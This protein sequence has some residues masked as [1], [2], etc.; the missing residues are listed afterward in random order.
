MIETNVPFRKPKSNNAMTAMMQK[1]IERTFKIVDD[2]VIDFTNNKVGIRTKAN[3]ILT[4][5]PVYSDPVPVAEG[6]PAQPQSIVDWELSQNIFGEMGFD[7]PAFAQ[8]RSFND[9]K[10]GDIILDAAGKTF[11]WVIE[12]KVKSL[13]VKRPSGTSTTYTAPNVAMMGTGAPTYM[14]IS[15]MM[16]GEMGTMLPMI[17]M[18]KEGGKDLKKMLPFMMMANQGQGAAGLNAMMPIMMMMGDSDSDMEKLL[19]MMMMMNPGMM[20]QMTG[21]PTQGTT[22]DQAA[23]QQANPM[24]GMMMQNNMMQMMMMQSFMGK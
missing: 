1:F 4:C 18:M 17:M 20:N 11:G 5:S 8:A 24:S 10:L 9:V 13:L 2:V 21:V 7:I 23:A 6:E 3:D 14:V 19:P 22:T 16:G 12:K 15:S